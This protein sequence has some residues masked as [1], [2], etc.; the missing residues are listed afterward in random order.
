SPLPG[1]DDLVLV[2]RDPV[3]G[4]SRWALAGEWDR[5]EAR[6]RP[7]VRVREDFITL[8]LP[9]LAAR[10]NEPIA[11]AVESYKHEAA[12]VDP[13]LSTPV[14]CAFKAMALADVCDRL[15]GDTGILL[16]AGARFADEKVK[17]FCEKL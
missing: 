14:T 9:R 1:V 4:E 15:R 11:E 8:P 17:I 3:K 5:P 7:A 16:T 13:R 12:I 6:V 10:S 2:N